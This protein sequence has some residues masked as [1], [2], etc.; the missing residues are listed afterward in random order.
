MAIRF[1]WGIYVLSVTYLPLLYSSCYICLVLGPGA[2]CPSVSV[3]NGTLRRPVTRLHPL[4]PRFIDILFTNYT[5][6]LAL[7]VLYNT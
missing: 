4:K 5:S 2:Q 3:N 1:W 6:A 7:I